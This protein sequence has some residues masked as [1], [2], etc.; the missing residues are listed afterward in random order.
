MITINHLKKA[1]GNTVACD[2]E[3]FKINDG[4][5]LGLVGNNGAGKTTLFRM[6]LDLLKPDEG[7]VALDGINPAQ[8][9]EWKAATGSYIDEGFLIDFLTPEEYFA[10]I[11][12]ITDKT[13][14]EV[15]ERLK[16]F[17]KFAAGEIFGQKKLIRNLSAGNKQKVGIISALFN[18][19]KLVILDEPF[20]FLDPSSQNTLK[21]VLTEYNR[22]TGATI[23]VSSHNLAH[24]IDISTRIALLEK[25]HIV[26]DLAN[27]DGSARA[28][29]E[30]Y[31]ETE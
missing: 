3:Q 8:S 13:Q 23:L 17:E 21:H 5:I 11:G 16:D 2:I 22:R 1:F 19:P 4:E 29:L 10:F 20:N 18:N 12:K 25:G 26:R 28:E 30:N 24:T 27:A 14:E 31:F 15:D 6:L 9:E 7:D